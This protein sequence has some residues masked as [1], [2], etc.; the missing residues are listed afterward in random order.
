MRGPS[1][2]AL[3]L[4]LIAFVLTASSLVLSVNLRAKVGDR[5]ALA[6]ALKPLLFVDSVAASHLQE[7]PSWIVA[8]LLA[9]FNRDDEGQ[10]RPRF[11]GDGT[12][13]G[14]H[15]GSIP[16]TTVRSRDFHERFSWK[17]WCRA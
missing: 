14:G 3:S 6:V 7:R 9:W 12:D 2:F 8:G 10:P 5:S 16:P 15:K 17:D 11:S 4:L 13:S 1:R